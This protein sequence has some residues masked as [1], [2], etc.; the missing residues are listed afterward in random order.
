[1][2]DPTYPLFP[3][4][5][6]LGFI[7]SLIPLPWH[8]QAWNS[9]T[10]YF[11]MWTSISCLNQFVNSIV[12][13]NNALNPSPIWCEISIRILMGASVG[14]PLASLCINRRLYQIASSQAVT[15]TRGEKRRAILIDTT[16]CVLCPL[17]FIALQYVIQ[18]HR[19]NIYEDIGCYPALYNTLLTYFISSM[20]PAVIGLT[21]AVYCFLSLR[22]FA[23]RRLEFSQFMNSGN[24]SLTMGRY[25]RLMGLAATDILLTTPLSIF[26][27]WVNAS[28]GPLDPWRS[29]EDTHFNYS[30]IEQ[31]PR[32]YWSMSRNLVLGMTFTRWVPI[33]C[34][35]IFFAFFGFADEAKKNYRKAF[36]F[37]ANRFGVRQ[38]EKPKGNVPTIGHYNKPKAPLSPTSPSASSHLPPY[39]P[40]PP[41]FYNM[42]DMKRS[43]TTRTTTTMRSIADAESQ[44]D[45]VSTASILHHDQNETPKRFSWKSI[46]LPASDRRYSSYT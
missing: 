41:S 29:W 38:P 2:A 18:G 35:L 45:D 17:L 40:G 12:W 24:S 8:L 20:W 5:S 33:F 31:V 11:M 36:W 26:S 19:F 4:F 32:F 3:I 7:L 9:G 6:F 46:L 39:S 44:R 14:I 43:E 27:M 30:R 25:F 1:M 28:G 21:S 37:V 34:A 15:I 23:R 22:A 16:L 13:H 42:S 10:C